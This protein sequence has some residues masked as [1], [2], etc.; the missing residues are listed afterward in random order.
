MIRHFRQKNLK[1]LVLS[2]I[3]NTATYDSS[4][5]LVNRLF[6]NG[7]NSEAS[8]YITLPTDCPQRNERMGWMGDA[9]VYALAGSYNANTYQFLR[10]WL[11]TVQKVRVKTV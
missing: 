4:N 6:L 2:S 11:D 10:Q 9:N 3:D 7:Q 8:N 5:E 1:S